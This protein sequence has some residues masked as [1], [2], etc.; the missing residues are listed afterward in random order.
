MQN[1]MDILW[2]HGQNGEVRTGCAAAGQKFSM[3]V[4]LSRYT[5]ANFVRTVSPLNR[6]GS[7]Q[8]FQILF[9]SVRFSISST[10]FSF[11]WFRFSHITAM[12]VHAAGKTS[13]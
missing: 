6:A 4:C 9:D 8:V 1:N 12:K 13:K 5:V 7:V 10:R 2:H 3:F 11:F